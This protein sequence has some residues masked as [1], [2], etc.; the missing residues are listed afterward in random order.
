MNGG[1]TAVEI[2][3]D[4]QKVRSVDGEP[5]PTRFRYD[6]HANPLAVEVSLCTTLTGAQESREEAFNKVF[7]RELLFVGLERYTNNGMGVS[8]C[9]WGLSPDKFI[10]LSMLIPGITALKIRR[11]DLAWFLEL[12]QRVLP[13]AIEDEYL[14]RFIEQLSS[15]TQL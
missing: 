11:E 5:I 6:R 14:D 10:V 15:Q 13:R 9:P 3:F 12:T 2:V 1:P 8:V 7:E 4:L